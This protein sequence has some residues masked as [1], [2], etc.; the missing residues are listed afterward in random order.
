MHFF[1]FADLS[2]DLRGQI[3]RLANILKISL[4]SQ[5]LSELTEANTFASMRKVAEASE[6]RFHESSPL[7]DQ[8]KFFASGTSNKWEGRL[9]DEDIDRYSDVCAS[10]LPPEDAAWLN[11]GD[12]RKP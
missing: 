9:K 2:R 8:A 10:L 7:I 12:Q 6:M 1:H 3:E 11:W 5:F 4:S